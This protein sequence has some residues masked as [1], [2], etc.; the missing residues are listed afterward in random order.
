MEDRGPVWAGT[1]PGI[2]PADYGRVPGHTASVSP[3]GSARGGQL[4]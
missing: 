2:L 4:I 3:R 1:A